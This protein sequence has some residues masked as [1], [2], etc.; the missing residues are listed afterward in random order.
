MKQNVFIELIENLGKQNIRY[1]LLR[2]DELE[3]M[4]DN[5]IDILIRPD[6]KDQLKEVMSNSNFSCWKSRKFLKK[7]VYAYF[8]GDQLLLVDVHYALIQN[9]IEY[10]DMDGIFDRLRMV[11][12]RFFVL[13]NEDQLL[14]YFYH[15]MLGKNHIQPKHLESIKKLIG[16]DLDKNYL[17]N[18]IHD[19]TIYSIL[20]V[21]TKRPEPFQR[22]S[23]NIAATANRIEKRLL[24][25]SFRNI[26]RFLYRRFIFQKVGRA[27]GIHFA[28][29]G[30]DG[31]GKSSLIDS[32]QNKLDQTKGVKFKI[33]YMGPW[34]QSRSPIHRWLKRKQITLPKEESLIFNS[35]GEKIKPPSFYTSVSNV[36]KATIYYIGV[37]IELWHRYFTEVRPARNSGQIVLSDR[38]IFDLRY[39]YKKRIVTN[40]R[41]M[42]FLVCELFP[43]PDKIV[44]LHN[45]P[46]V[47]FARKPQLEKSEIELFQKL[48]LKALHKYN[49]MLLKSD[50]G[51]DILASE[52]L[53]E[54]FSMLLRGG[55]STN[56][57][58]PKERKTMQNA[59]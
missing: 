34:G 12:D 8:D 7:E 27:P 49:P 4:D 39:I 1:A 19:S 43:T 25:R 50:K 45:D 30:V 14:H 53:K 47:I 46:E 37:Y 36:V 35:S 22:K 5:E 17:R 26:I 56:L 20:D 52:I 28:L 10:L 13:S 21:F 9:G 23:Y 48:Y 51:P 59:M 24:A 58:Y 40:H 29:I 31:A 57:N 11:N 18:K 16:G 42:R 54:I 41:L 44:F 15:N 33:V 2:T 3:S 32:L 38:Y 55:D 6:H